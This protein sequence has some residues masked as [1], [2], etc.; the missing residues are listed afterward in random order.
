MELEEMQAAWSQ[1]SDQ[2]ETQKKL[3]NDI[4]LKMTQQAYKNQWN[5]IAWPE[6]IGTFIC[7]T[8]LILLLVNFRRLDSFPLQV[9]GVLCALIMAFLPIA[10]L[11]TIRAMQRIDISK[12]NYKQ[13]LETYAKEKKRFVF[14]Q[15]INIGISFVFM[16][17]T[18]PVFSKLFNDKDFFEIFNLK[19]L[20]SLPFGILFFFLFIAFVTRCYKGVIKRSDTILEELK[21]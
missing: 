12:N 14:F 15:K 1:M 20:Y 8:A 4:I 2:L 6:K 17:L 11:R 16:F 19:L 18:I 5:K 7:Y 13:T 9:S 3:T 10:S 21:E